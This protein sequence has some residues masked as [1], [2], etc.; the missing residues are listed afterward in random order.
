[1]T[2]KKKKAPAKKAAAKKQASKNPTEDDAA[3]TTTTAPPEKITADQVQPVVV[4]LLEGADAHDLTRTPEVA[5]A[6]LVAKIENAKTYVANLIIESQVDY[7]KAAEAH[8]ELHGLHKAIELQ[9]TTAKKPYYEV[10]S[11]IMSLA[12]KLKSP[13]AELKKQV[14]SIMGQYDARVEA[15]RQACLRK[16]EEEQKAA[17]AA[18][19]AARAKEM[20][21][22]VAAALERGELPPDNPVAVNT[23]E[24]APPAPVAMMSA[25]PKSVGTAK[26][27]R[28]LFE[29][30]PGA[31][32]PAEY[33][34]T[35]VDQDKVK[36]A[37]SAGRLE[38]EGDGPT[39]VG[40][41][42]RVWIE[43]S[44]RQTGR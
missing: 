23:A 1:M 12:K 18:A 19:E 21:E 42:V 43:R 28:T 32:V 33:L 24:L 41:W 2:A 37:V 39:T 38:P 14:G 25:V 11:T 35:V 6:E 7:D 26:I 27:K 13:V 10:Y 8:K 20:Q 31:A 4:E 36:A 40:G 16:A 5:R 3:E 30:I 15:E 22:K 17:L 34:M 29:L 9:E 44:V